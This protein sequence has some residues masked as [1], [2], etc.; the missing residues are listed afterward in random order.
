MLQPLL[1]AAGVLLGAFHL[2]LFGQQASEGQLAYA[3]SV[4][5]LTAAGL[6]A[7][8]AVLHRQGAS[9][10]RGRRAT[11]IWVLAA[12]LHGPA[13]AESTL[14]RQVLSEA[15]EVATQLVGVAAGLSLALALAGAR[16]AARAL[17]TLATVVGAPVAPAARAGALVVGFCP[18]P[19]PR[20]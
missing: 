20:G 6:I 17:R 2:W 15:A 18:R 11:A 12:L 16:R 13:L 7:G 1:T 5:W 4:R 8:L 3:E 14:T 9:L 10:I 19:P